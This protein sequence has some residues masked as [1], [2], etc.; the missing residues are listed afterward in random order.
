MKP[1]AFTP[2]LRRGFL[3]PLIALLLLLVVQTPAWAQAPGTGTVAGVVTDPQDAVIPDAAVTLTNKGTGATQKATTLGDGHY[4]LANVPPGI[5]DLTFTKKGF[6]TAKVSNQQVRVGITT[7]AN[8]KLKVGA[9]SITVEVTATGAEL[10]TLDASVGNVFD[11]QALEKL[12]SL[13]R[14]ATA[15]LLIQPLAAPGLNGAPGSGEGNLTGGGIAGARA[16]QNTFM[17]DGGDATSNTEGG[18]GYAQQA[19]SG[20]AATPRAAIPTPV[21]SLQ[22]MRV[23]TNNSNTFA[24]SSGGE[25]QMV[26]RSGNNG[27][28]GAAYE[29]NQNTDYN[30]NSWANNNNRKPGAACLT[31]TD[32]SCFGLP[33]SVWVD[34][35]YG[36]RLGGPILKDKAFFFLMYEGHNFKKGVPF[37]RLVP[38]DLLRQGIMQYPDAGGTIHQVNFLTDNTICGG[39][40][41]PRHKGL[42]PAIASIWALEPTG[43]DPSGGVT[44]TALSDGMNTIGFTSNVPVVVNDSF[45]VGRLDYKLS[46]NWTF[47]SSYHYAVS[48]GV[49]AGQID[50]GGL[51][52]GDTK[53]TPTALRKLPTQPRYFTFGAT[54]HVG[55]NLTTEAHFNWLRHWWQWSPVSPFPQVPSV[56]MNVQIYAENVVNGMVPINVDTQ[57]ARARN[58]NGKDF[59]WGDNSTWL[60]GKHILSFGGEFRHEHFTHTRDDKV[61]G[62]LTSPQIYASLN[63]NFTGGGIPLPTGMDPTFTDNWKRAY[64]AMTGMV[65]RA[66]RLLTRGADFSPNAPGTPLHQDTI[67]D[68]YNL[69]FTD[70]WRMTNTFTL[71]LGL[72]WGAQTPPFENTGL[73][74]IMV[75]SATGQPIIFND[76]LANLAASAA[77]GTV[78]QP[79]VAFA[80]IKSLGRKY[81]YDPEWNDF[82]PRLSFAWNPSSFLP[83]LLGDRKTVIRAGYGRYHDRLNGVGLVM[84][85]A[86]GIGFGNTVQCR[87]PQFTGSFNV[88]NCDKGKTTAANAFRIGVD[89]STLPLP[90]LSPITGSLIPG[91][92]TGMAGANSPFEILD[93]RIDPHRKVGVE[94]TWT[95]S[96]ERSLPGKSLLEIGYVGRVAHHLY[97]AG[98]VGQVPYMLTMGGQTFASAYD[99]VAKAVRSGAAPAPQ[100]F[101]E[102]ALGPGG[103]AKV[104]ANEATNFKQGHAWL[105]FDDQIGL[106]I[107]DLQMDDEQISTSIGNSNYHA[108]YVSFRKQLTHGLLMQANYTYAH[109]LD[110]IGFTQENVFITPSDNFNKSRDYG[111]SLFDRRHTLNLFMVY[112][113]PFGKGHALANGGIADKIFGGWTISSAF[114]AASAIPVLVTDLSVSGECDQ[115][116]NGDGSGACGNSQI[117]LPGAPSTSSANYSRDP[118]VCGNKPGNPQGCVVPFG[119]TPGAAAALFREPF[120]SDLRAGAGEFRSYPRWNMDAAVSKTIPL[121]ERFKLGFGMQAVN[122]FNHMDFNDPSLDVSNIKKFGVTTGQYSSP[123]FLNLNVRVDF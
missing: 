113:L 58:W 57:N 119:I 87:R 11:Q 14:D 32:P 61:V 22:E 99:A 120:F 35:R 36:G 6:E 39:P 60:K 100:P 63:S 80:P 8:I 86:L 49:G 62:S 115:W 93:F 94:D 103:T 25:V 77:G 116:G 102:K 110:T 73:Q 17:L 3:W 108:G 59:T 101:W 68:F 12:P 117:A 71:T 79:G 40:C 106:P 5:Y 24:R 91:S 50:I 72:G 45:A 7:T 23:V 81:P 104:A 21:E 109:S 29:N 31:S 55:P 107:Q 1:F 10:Q 114:V 42:S 2:F 90:G 83:G 48:D 69:Y 97:G 43:N 30:A 27:W 89:G 82:E 20:F 67:V 88:V 16:D 84:T 38:S 15:I 44:G 9:E 53:G 18:G 85:P 51:V 92:N 111:P 122:V 123:R 33:R 64:V 28:H 65:N 56:G 34:N 26:T 98:D 105:I 13:S 112:D 54:G 75:N 37:T 76:F 95:M 19:A 121:T 52:P 96:I 70:S 74:T 66:G 47:N 46:N 118:A 4:L 78:N 41:D